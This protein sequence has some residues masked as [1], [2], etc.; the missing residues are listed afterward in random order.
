M[1]VRELIESRISIVDY[2]GQFTDL[3]QA[4]STYKGKCP[5]HGSEEHMPL[6]VFP[7]TNSY[8]CFSCNSG[9][10]PVAFLA[11]ME[12]IPYRMATEK[13]AKEYNI[14]LG[15]NKEYQKEVAVEQQFTRE[16]ER[17]H[18]QVDK[19][20]EYLH[21]RKINDHTIETF[22]LGCDNGSLTIPLCN[23]F[24]QYVAMARRVFDGKSK[25]INSYN[26]SLYTKGAN[27]FN[28]HR[29]I[30]LL[31]DRDEMYFVEGYMDAISGHQMGLPVVAY[32]GNELTRE[33]I[34]TIS[35]TVRKK[36][37]FILVPDNDKEG[38]RR[39]P[40]VR[41]FFREAMPRANVRV[42]LV[43]DG[44][45]DMND[46]LVAGIEPNKLETV[47]ID[48]FVLDL[49]LKK[50]K[51]KEDEYEIVHNFLHT[52]S[53]PLIKMD[54][55]KDMAGRWGRDYEELREYFNAPKE[56]VDT[57]VKN[58]ALTDGCISDLKRLYSRGEYPTHFTNLDR[59]IGGLT[60]KQVFVIGAFSGSGKSDI[61]IEYIL[62]QV[63][64]NK[65]KT[66]FFSLEMPKGKVMERII[67]KIVGCPL[68]EVRELVMKG[69]PRL[70][71]V[72]TKLNNS[73][74]IYDDND[75]SM[76]DIDARIQAVNQK[77]LLGGPVDLVV[78]DYFTYI[79]GA[80]TFE[81]ASEQALM[82]KGIAKKH[83]IIFTMLSQI[84][85][86]GNTYEEPTMD[87]LRMTGD[88]ENSA[89]VI[90]MLWMPSREPGISLAKQQELMYITRMKVEKA[91][92]GKYGP[93]R[94]E[95][96]YNPSNSRLEEF[97][98]E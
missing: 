12:D 65:C 69:D 15:E 46:M 9:G 41:E 57:L 68:R 55:I 60:K 82:M 18:K 88:I 87:M 80:N 7:Q 73:L 53:I 36:I 63:S 51:K 94:M 25:Y 24:G 19:V 75:L 28:L 89:D 52:V 97:V 21:K 26:N 64:R 85:R 54:I 58:A 72:I 86:K 92:D 59:C 95:L 31:R 74:I 40:R 37:T 77:N 11:D 48:R 71:Q 8:Y 49:L 78:V 76:K 44:C 33:Q 47:H 91:R 38:L 5:I 61:A 84:S 2:I 1:K 32:C 27:L 70:S 30:Q 17:F 39:V 90:L 20:R 83:N 35:K 81:G 13:L 14:D 96:K 62:R 43:P 34:R 45:K 10:G 93:D 50:A 4:G 42:A 79:K 16:A 67:A 22:M 66:I 3:I 29:A 98:R 6:V 56:D 23:E